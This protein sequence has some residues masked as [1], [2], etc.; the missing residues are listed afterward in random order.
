MFRKHL[1]VKKS[2][3]KDACMAALKE[4][5]PQATYIKILRE[6]AYC[7]GSSW[8]YKSGTGNDG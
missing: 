5:I 4:D 3:I 1:S 6:L 2:D 8:I 7:K